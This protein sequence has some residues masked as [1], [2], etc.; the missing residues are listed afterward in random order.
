M[1]DLTKFGL[2]LPDGAAQL[3]YQEMAGMAVIDAHEHLFP[4]NYRLSI[5]PDAAMLFQEQYPVI[6]LVSSG[7]SRDDL[8]RVGNRDLELE[9]RWALLRPHLPNIRDLSLTR[10]LMIG[11]QE[12]YGFAAVTDENYLD[13]TAA[14]QAFNRPGIYRE[15]LG[16]RCRIAAAL[17]QQYNRPDPPWELPPADTVAGRFRRGARA[18]AGA[19]TGTRGVGSQAVQAGHRSRA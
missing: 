15:V 5:P 17:V 10:A 16:D 14:M 1:Q 2:R 8:D 6:G 12:L 7:M 9:Q 19:A 18:D 11:V 4:E 13:V 3:L